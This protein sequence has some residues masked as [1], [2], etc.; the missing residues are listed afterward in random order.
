MTPQTS[1]DSPPAPALQPPADPALQIVTLADERALT[2][3]EILQRYPFPAGR[4]WLRMNFISSL[5]GA[6]TLAGRA[7]GLGDPADQR[8]L[9][10][11][12]QEADAI[13][14]GAGTVRAE[15]YGGMRLGED[16]VARRAALGL[17]TQPVFVLIS[18]ALDLDPASA[19]FADAPVR[20]VICTVQGAPQDRREALAEVAEVLI[21]GE[22]DVDPL[23]V[24]S[25]L[26][27]RG[28]VHLHGEGGP[29]VLGTFLAAG[30]VDELCLTLS[31]MLVAG[32]AG[33]ITRGGEE[34]AARMHLASMLRAGD[35]LL[36]RYV[37]DSGPDTSS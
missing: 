28:L 32:A 36:L 7:G 11:L 34:I 10:L 14:V 6:V 27:Q 15:G 8:L 5:D 1:P 9:D 12:R 13:L 33:R 37:R 2:D 3:A 22:G 16:A 24:R 29:A 26:A 18:R 4:P 23:Q 31:P 19:V 20:P 30:A 21:T 35:E 25:A 17:P